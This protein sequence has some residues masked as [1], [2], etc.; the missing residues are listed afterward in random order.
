MG[1]K[2]GLGDFLYPKNS[3]PENLIYW[4]QYIMGESSMSDKMRRTKNMKLD[5][6]LFYNKKNEETSFFF[7]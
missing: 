4:K 6:T 2:E 7:P 5:I 1:I 3:V